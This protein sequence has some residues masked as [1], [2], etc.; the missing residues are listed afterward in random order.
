MAL[1]VVL[2]TNLIVAALLGGGFSVRAIL[3]GTHSGHYQPLMGAALYAEYSDVAS[4]T[5]LFTGSALTAIERVEVMDAL[6]SVRRWVEIYYLWRPNLP[7][8]RDNHLIEL[9]LAGGA[10]AIITR[11]ICDV[12]RGELKF[13]DLHILTPSNSWSN[14]RVHRNATIS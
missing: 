13:P 9:A 4:R 8:E 14:L 6:F 12:A 7:D 1:N 5:Q 3:R 10:S 11:N 2:D